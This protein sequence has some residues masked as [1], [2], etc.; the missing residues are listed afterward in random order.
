MSQ[1][2]SSGR[3]NGT[4]KPG[5]NP[6]RIVPEKLSIYY[7]NC[8]MVATSPVDI[9]LYFGRYVQSDGRD[10]RQMAELYERQIY[11]T[12]QQAK[13]LAEVLTQTIQAVEKAQR[14]VQPAPAQKPQ[15]A[16]PGVIT[17]STAPERPLPKQ[18]PPGK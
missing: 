7:S 17:A 10:G 13:N 8:A 11:M 6:A 18:T 9:S 3:Q 1:S 15:P 16:R 4:D 2:D 14:P 12:L 5:A